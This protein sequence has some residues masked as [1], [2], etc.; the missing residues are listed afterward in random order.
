MKEY[1]PFVKNIKRKSTHYISTENC[2][3]LQTNKNKSLHETSNNN[4]VK[5]LVGSHFSY[6]I[7]KE[8]YDCIPHGTAFVFTQV[9]VQKENSRIHLKYQVENKSIL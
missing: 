7:T 8:H 3:R 9:Q 6:A 5:P 4:F 1:Y 2:D